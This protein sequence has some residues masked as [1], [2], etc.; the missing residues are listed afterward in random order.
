M[1]LQCCQLIP[2]LHRNL[3]CKYPSNA[4]MQT[5]KSLNYMAD[6][7]PSD[8]YWIKFVV[9]GLQ[10]LCNAMSSAHITF[11]GACTWTTK[12]YINLTLQ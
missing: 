10:I 12:F 8:I 1:L 3:L 7:S 4:I 6:K 2:F 9:L 11:K 5:D